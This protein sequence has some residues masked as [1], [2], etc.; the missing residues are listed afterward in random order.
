[1]PRR[2][3]YFLRDIPLLLGTKMGR[4]K[5]RQLLWHSTWPLMRRMAGLYR[6]TLARKCRVVTV[7]GSFGKTTTSRAVACALDR[8]LGLVGGHN[9][10][11][12]VAMAVLGIRPGDRHAVLEVGIE[13][14]GEMGP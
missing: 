7:V 14:A 12:G 13:R 6:C 11:N 5:F 9:S 10:M 2:G 3:Q 8:D 1:M 4:R